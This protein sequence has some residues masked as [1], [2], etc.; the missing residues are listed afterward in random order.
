MP[1]PRADWAEFVVISLKTD[2]EL[3]DKVQKTLEVHDKVL[4]AYVFSDHPFPLDQ[5]PS[6]RHNPLTLDSASPR[7]S[8]FEGSD[9][10][11]LRTSVFSFFD[12]L[13]LTT[14]SLQYCSV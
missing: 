3:N 1:Y 7:P 11:M 8:T 13:K 4:K 12:F 6:T 5:S 2:K 14:S 10:K 9:P